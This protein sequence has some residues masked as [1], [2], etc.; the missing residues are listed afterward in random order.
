MGNNKNR[1]NQNQKPRPQGH[2]QPPQQAEVTVSEPDERHQP[3]PPQPPQPPPQAARGGPRFQVP[4]PAMAPTAAPPA[5]PRE[6]DAPTPRE[7]QGR[8]PGPAVERPPRRGRPDRA[9]RSVARRTISGHRPMRG[10]GRHQTNSHESLLRH[11]HELSEAY[12]RDP[13]SVDPVQLQLVQLQAMATYGGN[14]DAVL[15]MG[16]ELKGEIARLRKQV[17]DYVAGDQQPTQA[18]ANGPRRSA[19]R[20][21]L[22]RRNAG[23]RTRNG[24]P[25]RR[26]A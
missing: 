11:I 17:A 21:R 24:I 10:V 6:P 23:R 8:Q 18:A 14:V 2:P 7:F 5:P 4:V 3:G 26:R 1:H 12:N 19:L 16:N 9:D 22:Q 25:G 13:N 15:E 20:E